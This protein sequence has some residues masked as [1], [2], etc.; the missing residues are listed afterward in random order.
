MADTY[1]SIVLL[2]GPEAQTAVNLLRAEG[3]EAALE[4]LKRWHEPGEGTL[5]S[6]RDTPWRQGDEVFESGRHVM[7][8][9]ASAPYIG[10]VFKIE[11]EP[12]S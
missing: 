11:I 9:D 4:H 8:L 2:H 12:P 7:Y 1:E 10:L 3:V 6:T 5:V